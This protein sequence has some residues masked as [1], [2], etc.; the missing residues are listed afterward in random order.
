MKSDNYRLCLMKQSFVYVC[1]CLWKNYIS[2]VMMMMIDDDVEIE[3][4]W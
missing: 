4:K 2:M 3:K 1:V